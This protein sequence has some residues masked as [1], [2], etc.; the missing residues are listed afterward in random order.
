MLES[1]AYIA[2]CDHP[3]CTQTRRLYVRRSREDAAR[4]LE[5]FGWTVDSTGIK[6]YEGERTHCPEHANHAT[7]HTEDPTKP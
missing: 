2:D 5:A 1:V 6:P 7:P 3:Q 4:Q